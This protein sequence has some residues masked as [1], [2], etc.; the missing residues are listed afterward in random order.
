[1]PRHSSRTRLGAAALGLA[2]ALFLLYPALRPWHDET[3]QEGALAAMGDGAWIASH[4]FAI[5][6]FILVPL[7][8]F[9]LRAAIRDTRAEPVAFA[10]A[11]TTWGGAGL[12]LPYY[13]AETFGLNAMAVRAGSGTFIDLVALADAV[14]FAPFAVTTF[15]LGL[16]LLGIGALLAAVAVHRSGSLPPWSGAPFALGF[17]LFLPQFFT[18][19]AVRIAHGVLVAAGCVALAAVIWNA[20]ARVRA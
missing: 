16:A 8:L 13:G 17:L 6:G 9:A 12:T 7:G 2:G 15:V 18:P 11:I 5:L 4:F 20:P 19:P 3:T 14:R 1:M 10:A